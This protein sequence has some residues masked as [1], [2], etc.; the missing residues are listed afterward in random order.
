MS[1]ILES[2]P[3]FIEFGVGVAAAPETFGGGLSVS[4]LALSKAAG[5]KAARKAVSKALQKAATESVMTGSKKGLSLTAA[6]QLYRNTYNDMLK[7][8]ATKAAKEMGA[9]ETAKIVAKTTPQSIIGYSVVFK[10][11]YVF[12]PKKLF[13]HTINQTPY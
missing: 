3:Y 10:Y 4:A 5:K 11:L 6:K 1:A 7:S 8:G 12:L 2:I 9:K 13:S